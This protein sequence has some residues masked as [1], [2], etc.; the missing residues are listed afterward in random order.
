MSEQIFAKEY[1]DYLI[2]GKEEALNSLT[3][4][5]IEKEYFVLI[6]KL[7]NEE[8]TPKLQK[9]IDSF[10][11]RV[12]LSQSFRLKALNIFKKLQK[13]ADKKQEII[14]D[15]ESSFCLGIRT[16]HRKHMKPVKY[17]KVSKD[18]D[19]KDDDEEKL[20]NSLDSNNFIKTKKLFEDIYN[21]KVDPK[22]EIIKDYFQF[23]S[24]NSELDCN[25]LSEDLI[26]K[27]FTDKE[28]KLFSNLVINNI[29]YLKL[30]TFQKVVKKIIKKCSK[31]EGSSE[32]IMTMEEYE[33]DKFLN[34]QIN[35]LIEYRKEFCYELISRIYDDRIEDNLERVKMFKEIQKI[36]N[37]F[38]ND[39]TK[40]K[41]LY[42]I[43]YLN[44]KMNIYEL[45]TFIEY[46]QF[47]IFD[48]PSLF[49]KDLKEKFEGIEDQSDYLDS[50]EIEFKEPTCNEEE[51]ENLIKKYLKHFYL[52]E[53]VLFEKFNKYFNTDFIKHF[54]SKMQFYLG[55]EEPLKDNL[56][57][58]DEIN[59][60]MD[61]TIL[62]ICDFNKKT[63]NIND[64]IELILE[65][66]NINTLYLNIY[67]INT[68]NYYYSN[69]N[70]F[71]ESISLDGIVPTYEDIYSYNDK[72]QLLTGKKVLI[73]KLPK[74]RGL[75]VVE[76]IGNG[77]VSRAV[78][79]KGNLRC[80]HK[81]TINEK[82][83]YILDEENKIC[84]G[85]KTGLWINN[86]WYPSIGD[87]GAILIPYSINGG[88]FILK[89]EDFCCLENSISIPE[90]NYELSGLF[91]INEESFLM[92]NI[93]KILVRPYLFVCN[94]LCPLEYLKNVKLTIN[95]IKT[96][97]NQE[98]P[99]TT[100]IDN[101]KLSYNKEFS[102]EFQVPAKLISVNFSLSG[103]IKL[104][105]RDKIQTLSIS[106]N[107]NFNRKF[108]Y[109]KLMKQDVNG[110]YILHLLGKNGEPKGNHQVELKF[111]FKGKN[112]NNSIL[113]ESDLEGKIN[114]GKLDEVK[115]LEIDKSLFEIQQLPKF[116]YLPSM[117]ILENQ[118]IN[119]PFNI[120]NGYG[121][122]LVRFRE[123]K[124]IENLSDL[125][126]IKITDEKHNLGNITLP[127]LSEGS[128]KMI[129][130]ENN[131]IINVIKG[132]VMDIKD[133]IVT[134]SGNIKYNNSF[135]TSIAIENVSYEGKELRIKLNKNNKSINNPRVH[136]NC[137]QY[138]PKRLNKNVMS[139]K[140]SK[141]FNFMKEKEDQEF[142]SNKATNIY[143]NNKILSDEI[144]YVLDRKQYEINLGN[145]L[146]KPSL[147]LKPQF[148]RDTNTEI[149]KGREGERFRKLMENCEK[150]CRMADYSSG[151]DNEYEIEGK[152]I[153]VHD[154]INVSPLIEENLIPN[155]NGEV[156]LKDIDLK[157]YSFLHILCFDNISCNEDCFC[158][159]NGVTSLRDLRAVNDLELNK[160]YCELRKIYPLSKKDKHHIN[161]ITSTKF[162]IFDSLE[163]YVEFINIINPSL[164]KD[165][166]DFSFLLNFNNLNLKEKLEKI[167]QYFSHETNIY[168]YFHHNDFFNKY[169]YPIL[170]YKSEKTFIDY[171]LLDYKEKIL[172]FT[173][174]QKIRQLNTFEKCLLIYTIRKDNKKLACSL[175]RQ[176]RAQ[177]PKENQ[178]EIKRLFNIALNLKSTEEIKEKKEMEDDDDHLFLK[179]LRV[180]KKKKC[181][182]SD[183][184][185][186]VD[187]DIAD[188]INEKVKLFKEQGNAKEYCETQYY[189]K[190]FKNIVNNSIVEPNHFFADL[191]KYW[192]ENDSIRNI[193]FK[194][195]NI[196]I[197]PKNL[198]E[199]IFM[200]S[201][202][203]L[204]EKT[205][206][207]SQNLI[208]DKGLG[209][210]IEANTNAYLLTKEINETQLNSDNNIQ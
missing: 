201:V 204:E 77:H 33:I 208:S 157:E 152:E 116:T 195:D 72:P 79:Q 140:G 17:N 39:K 144:Q 85:E 207:Q 13:S 95:T 205:M 182:T 164:N 44:S 146:E 55:K 206:P 22:N 154:F 142:I 134:D 48:N 98:I 11:K 122:H 135:E 86:V 174:L 83:V 4:R 2:S 156:I 67:E 111:K 192:S 54:Y 162:K 161:D 163:K 193:G 115:E 25:K 143:L 36:S 69:E 24:D 150:C 176:I 45:D 109:D 177:S 7:L 199:I 49:N 63:F 92:G 42:Y 6:R 210:T 113:L 179:C 43:L 68:E 74:N 51:E 71:D 149:K 155:E 112:Y 89:H 180:K 75:F 87:T 30:D 32:R 91:I 28:Y 120:I 99:S 124:I 27:A 188:E 168:L 64:D 153:K 175:A 47:P 40:R 127:K 70:N 97:N 209:L 66:K 167:T 78:I 131:I 15:I 10:S 137:V 141:F 159:K 202:L 187:D 200:L 76:F 80:I 160:N 139:F 9:E 128:Y 125:L 108:E 52:K 119:L 185:F 23:H 26:V 73:S 103:E 16:S 184:Y 191:A 50:L 181:Y 14:E 101:I 123:N 196:L 35:A 41:V 57:S 130:N 173:K 121:V 8:L 118:Q 94:E 170:K 136:I 169:I 107:L 147:L 102:F 59:N 110:N 81:N 165:L 38:G 82:V 34:E 19:Q 133:F 194:P 90:E 56:L 186:D 198:T 172:E 93:A 62:S 3:S 60:L 158:L 166:E 31:D 20:P 29:T 105:T 58:S 183:A 46:L 190:V 151:R 96:E 37:K 178:S 145:S 106:K 171:F 12:E 61:E 138:L 203:D 114:L 1:E 129:I 88:T 132:K 117:T 100:V 189:N 148:I 197:Q 84:K 126:N 18:Q 104:K 65:I 5:S 21:N 53:K